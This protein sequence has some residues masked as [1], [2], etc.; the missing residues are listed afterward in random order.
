MKRIHIVG[1]KNSGKTTLIEDLTNQLTSQG[2]RVGTVKHTHHRHELDTP[3]KD[4]HR[5][6]EAGASVVGILSPGMTAVFRPA[7]PQE[8]V[9][10]RY[11]LFSSAFADCDVILVEGHLRADGFKIEVWRAATTPQPLAADDESISA[12]ITDDATEVSIP[13]HRR[14]DILSLATWVLSVAKG[15]PS[16]DM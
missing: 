3:G 9:S 11:D 7:E 6:R 8:D 16:Q 5:H 10:D 2:Y 12:V 1:S 4:S 13:I 14:S 15:V